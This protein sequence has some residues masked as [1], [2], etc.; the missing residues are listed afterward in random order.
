MPEVAYRTMT[1]GRPDKGMPPWQ[2][3][4]GDEVIWKIVTFL[5]TVQREP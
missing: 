3:V 4:L 1:T 5:E 2:A